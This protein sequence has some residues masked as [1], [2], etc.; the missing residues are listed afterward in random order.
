MNSKLLKEKPNQETKN[1]KS[2]IPNGKKYKILFTITLLA[3]IASL[4]FNIYACLITIKENNED[5]TK[6]KYISIQSNLT[7]TD[8]I[9]EI[10]LSKS[11]REYVNIW[12]YEFATIINNTPIAPYG[13]KIDA[14]TTSATDDKLFNSKET[15]SENQI[16]IM[17]RFKYNINNLESPPV[18]T[19]KGKQL[20]IGKFIKI[21]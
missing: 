17:V 18:F 15:T 9:C 12:A 7:S 13:I 3:L 21:L 14:Y 11:P 1:T 4:I 6:I 2:K 10:N 8:L 5:C 20:Q 19:Y 16:T